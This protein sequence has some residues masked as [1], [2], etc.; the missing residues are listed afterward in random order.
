MQPQHLRAIA[1]RGL[2]VGPCP[3]LPYQAGGKHA[4]IEGVVLTAWGHPDPSFNKV[5]AVGPTPPL[6][7]LRELAGAFFGGPGAY[8]V[9]VEADAGHPVEA[10]L[11]GAGWTVLEDEP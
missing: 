2:I 1:N 9:L 10:E 4:V 6:A 7:R 11:R 8:G 3:M 5:G